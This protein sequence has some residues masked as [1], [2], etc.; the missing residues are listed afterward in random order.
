MS[1]C[2]SPHAARTSL[3]MLLRGEVV[4]WL[5]MEDAASVLTPA[6]Q[7]RVSD[8]EPNAALEAL[9]EITQLLADSPISAAN[10]RDNLERLAVVLGRYETERT[11]SPITQEAL[12]NPQEAWTSWTRPQRREVVRLLFHHVLVEHARVAHGPRADLSR[13][14][15]IWR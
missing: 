6:A 4:R 1:L 11:S 14:E 15:L 8:A 13:L 9:A 2:R 12:V 7:R 3:T 10:A 5:S